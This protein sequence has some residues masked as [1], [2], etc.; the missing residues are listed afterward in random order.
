MSV[1][2]GEERAPRQGQEVSQAKRRL[3]STYLSSIFSIFVRYIAIRSR[4]RHVHLA[5][6]TAFPVMSFSTAVDFSHSSDPSTHSTAWAGRLRLFKLGV[7]A[8]ARCNCKAYTMCL[9][10]ILWPA[11]ESLHMTTEAIGRWV[12]WSR[13][14]DHGSMPHGFTPCFSF[15]HRHTSPPASPELA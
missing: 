14:T 15:R 8:D 2:T 6:L 3:V 13:S 1:C 10:L 11:G 5:L 7:S 4:H 12:M 9:C